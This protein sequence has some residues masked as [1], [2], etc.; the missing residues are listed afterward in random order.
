MDGKRDHDQTS[1]RAESI[2]DAIRQ[3]ARAANVEPI[4]SLQAIKE[5]VEKNTELQDAFEQ[6][7]STVLG[8]RVSEDSDYVPQKYPNSEKMFKSKKPK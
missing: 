6:E 7:I 2:P 4:T 5:D 1:T 3:A 8:E